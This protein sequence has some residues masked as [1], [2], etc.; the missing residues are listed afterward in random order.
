M[1]NEKGNIKNTVYSVILV[2]GNKK[3]SIYLYGINFFFQKIKAKTSSYYLW[4]DRLVG[5]EQFSLFIWN[6]LCLQ[7]NFYFQQEICVCTVVSDQVFI[8]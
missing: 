7:G 3:K 1:L 8:I 6:P 5:E 2:C 4:E